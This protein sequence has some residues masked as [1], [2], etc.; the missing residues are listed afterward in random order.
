MMGTMSFEDIYG[1]GTLDTLAG[2]ETGAKT[3]PNSQAITG[4]VKKGEENFLHVLKNKNLIG[5]PIIVWA[6]L[7][8]LLVALKYIVE[9]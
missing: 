2:A 6:G 4:N 5:Q 9:R 8:A 1:A 7:V 3:N